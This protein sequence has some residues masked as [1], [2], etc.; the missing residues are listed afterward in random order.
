MRKNI[1]GN[2]L[3]GCLHLHVRDV[4]EDGDDEIREALSVGRHGPHAG[5]ADDD[6]EGCAPETAGDGV[7]LPILWNAGV[8]F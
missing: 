1:V 5:A 8:N 7:C 3:N 2:C 4:R 6:V